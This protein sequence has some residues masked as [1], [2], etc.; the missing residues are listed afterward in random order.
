M[1]QNEVLAAVVEAVSEYNEQLEDAQKLELSPETRLLG[2]SSKLDSFGLV[3]LIIVVEEKLYEKFERPVT[4]ADE[5]AMSQE[6]SPFRSIESLA[7]YA[8]TLLD[9]SA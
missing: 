6:R 7:E 4:L 5:R 1:D 3:N 8:F 9:E 2:K